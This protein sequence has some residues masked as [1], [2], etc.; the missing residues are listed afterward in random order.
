MACEPSV[1]SNL[2]KVVVG[3]L[4]KILEF[5]GTNNIVQWAWVPVFLGFYQKKG[6]SVE[7]NQFG[8]PEFSLFK[9]FSIHL[10]ET[11]TE[12]LSVLYE[13]Q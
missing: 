6:S 8:G 12:T 1:L 4:K 13:H 7:I 11:K 10:G 3:S 9:F 5:Q 2:Q